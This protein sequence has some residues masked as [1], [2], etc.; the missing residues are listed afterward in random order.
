MGDPT[1][2]PASGYLRY[3]PA[4][5]Q[6]GP[7]IAPFLLGFEAILTGHVSAPP[8]VSSVP[9]GLVETLDSIAEY[10]DPRLAPLDFLPWLAQWVALTLRDDW[11]EKTRRNLI[12]SVV[13]LYHLRGTRKGIEA[14]LELCLDSRNA[15]VSVV[16]LRDGNVSFDPSYFEIHLTIGEREDSQA[17]ASTIRMI[18]SVANQQKPAHTFYKLVISYPTLQVLDQPAD[19]DDA[20]KH[21]SGIWVNRNTTL[22]SRLASDPS[23]PPE[24]P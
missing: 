2:T 5:L 17:L 19:G 7:F 10:F 1:T 14:A 23:N 9:R 20:D 3:L 6:E 11:S 15:T 21:T 22:G 24:T 12:A 13:P 8:S 16:D 18:E 4:I